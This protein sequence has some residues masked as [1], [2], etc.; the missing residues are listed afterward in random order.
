MKDSGRDL[1]LVALIIVVLI[2]V[3]WTVG[4]L[5]GVP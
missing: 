2:L 5:S 4:E 3:I 1:I